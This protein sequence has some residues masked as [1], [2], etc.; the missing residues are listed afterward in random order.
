MAKFVV[1]SQPDG[2]VTMSHAETKDQADSGES[3]IDD[4][5]SR[6][7]WE[8]GGVEATTDPLPAIV[9]FCW[10]EAPA[11]VFVARARL[12]ETFPDDG[13]T[14]QFSVYVQGTTVQEMESN[15]RE[16][17]QEWFDEAGSQTGAMPHVE[18]V[19]DGSF[20]VG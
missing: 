19:H 2:D 10:V 5:Y 3:S 7:L 8:G 15:A 11:G 6:A 1:R 18:F 13:R 12:N 14:K 9:R 4:L 17:I 16:H 20:L